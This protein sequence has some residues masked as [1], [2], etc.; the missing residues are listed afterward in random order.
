MIHCA[1]RTRTGSLHEDNEDRVTTDMDCGT[2]MVVDGMGGLADAA[3]TAQVIADCFPREV[4]ERVE[5]LSSPD[6]AREVTGVLAELNKH[7]RDTARSGPGTTGAAIAFLLVRDGLALVVHLGDSRIYLSRKGRI[8]C[9]TKDHSEDGHLTQFVGMPGEVE[10]GI[11][12]HELASGDRIL[13]CTDGLTGSVDDRALG[14]M[15]ASGGLDRACGR[16]VD[17]ATDG[18]AVDDISVVAVEFGVRGLG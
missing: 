16:L 15:L 10:P 11:S 14:R 6:V 2:F 12:V 5:A 17:A 18:G 13:L 4:C 1:S 8:R 7:V 9:L 3:A